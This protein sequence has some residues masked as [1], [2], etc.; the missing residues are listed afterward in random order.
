MED[1]D[2]EQEIKELGT[3]FECDT[4]NSF[5]LVSDFS[6]ID[7][8]KSDSLVSHEEFPGCVIDVG[9]EGH[10]Q[11]LTQLEYFVFKEKRINDC[12]SLKVLVGLLPGDYNGNVVLE[13]KSIFLSTFDESDE[14]IDQI[15]IGKI[16]R[17]SSKLWTMNSLV[18]EG[19]ISREEEV[20]W[21]ASNGDEKFYSKKDT[22]KIANSG[23][24]LEI[25]V[26][27][28]SDFISTSN[29]YPN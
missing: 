10:P 23:V 17:S 2:D 5:S 8:L 21:V 25:G 6:F 28:T 9:H 24:F 22:F 26:K 7:D 11:V 27:D 14:Q 15:L 18:S 3:S 12:F 13:F 29:S 16:N 4:Q 19:I 20:N 1:G